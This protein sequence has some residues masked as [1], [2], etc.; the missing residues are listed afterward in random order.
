MTLKIEVGLLK[1]L[2]LKPGDLV[3][4]KSK[5]S[6][7]EAI[8]FQEPKPTLARDVWAGTEKSGW[9]G[10]DAFVEVISRA[11]D[12]KG[13]PDP[14]VGTLRELKV[15]PGDEVQLVESEF[16][17]SDQVGEIYLIATD[18]RVKS[19]TAPKEYYGYWDSLT[20][21]QGSKWRIISRAADEVEP[22]PANDNDGV[23]Q[24]SQDA[25]HTIARSLGHAVIAH[26]EAGDY[27]QALKCAALMRRAEMEPVEALKVE[28]KGRLSGRS[29]LE[30]T[31]LEGCA[32]R[33]EMRDLAK[34]PFSCSAAMS[35]DDLA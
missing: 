18:G 22:Q 16:T 24:T 35:K 31:W 19:K 12:T 25:Y 26:V 29:F 20:S 14:S 30:G 6:T 28:W 3:R 17:N 7:M 13:E 27:E 2:N 9:L 4:W 1:D 33:H 5:Y 32:M 34:H 11:A 10:A 21:N 15:R 8:A 23:P